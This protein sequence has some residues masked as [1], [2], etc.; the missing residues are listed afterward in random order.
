MLKKS[1]LLEE[2]TK[3]TKEVEK[4]SKRLSLC[5]RKMRGFERLKSDF[6]SVISHQLRT[7]LSSIRWF[8]EEILMGKE[9]QRL[10][11]EQKNY[12]NQALRS[13]H[14]IADILDNLMKVAEL[15]NGKIALH[16]Q[17]IDLI[18][19]L[20]EALANF[21]KAVKEKKIKISLNV[22]SKKILYLDSKKI[23]HI[24]HILL[25]NAIKYNFVGGTIEI[26]IKDF[27]EKRRKYVLISIKNSGIGLPKSQLP[28][29]FSKFYRSKEGIKVDPEGSGLSLFIAKNYVEAHR[30]RI[31][32]ESQGLGKGATFKFLLP[33]KE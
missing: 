3:T 12:L 22:P 17:Y 10:S 2:L 1:E 31:W 25:D 6:I 29:V 28:K 32:A 24:L 8:L 19:L 5:E 13:T 20:S 15:E 30:G 27:S 14:K 11:E 23:S 18:T 26:S 4:V 7:P 21:E 16:C 33:V 9:N